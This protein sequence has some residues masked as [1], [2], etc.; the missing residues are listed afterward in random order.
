LLHVERHRLVDDRDQAARQIA[1][2][3]A[4]VEPVQRPV[5]TCSR[6]LR[7]SPRM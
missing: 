6:V 3:I 4:F 2:D 7:T 1:A 5:A